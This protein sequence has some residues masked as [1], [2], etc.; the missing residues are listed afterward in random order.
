MLLTR[1]QYQTGFLARSG[2]KPFLVHTYIHANFD[3]V[4]PAV[5]KGAMSAAIQVWNVLRNIVY[6]RHQ[7]A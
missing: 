7:I 1:G 4:R 6:I 2:N 3:Y 5:F